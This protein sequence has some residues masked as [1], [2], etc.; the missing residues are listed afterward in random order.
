MLSSPRVE[1]VVGNGARI[2]IQ[3]MPAEHR[4]AWMRR[5]VTS[6]ADTSPLQAVFLGLFS[7]NQ[8]NYVKYFATALFDI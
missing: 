8:R 1:T 4:L 7:V 5:R 3:E 6:L 2:G